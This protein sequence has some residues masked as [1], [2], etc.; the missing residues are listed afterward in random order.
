M[1]QKQYISIPPNDPLWIELKDWAGERHYISF[2]YGGQA[3]RSR[4]EW[5]VS[6][7]WAGK[8]VYVQKKRLSA[9]KLYPNLYKEGK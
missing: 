1:K 7:G 9:R 3:E 6:K 2:Y 4:W 5:C 8:F